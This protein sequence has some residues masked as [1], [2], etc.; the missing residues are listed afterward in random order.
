MLLAMRNVSLGLYLLFSGFAILEQRNKRER[1][2]QAYEA[3]CLD[4]ALW[5]VCY[6]ACDSYKNYVSAELWKAILLAQKKL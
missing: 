6:I 5:Y 2:L 4:D 1:E 3:M